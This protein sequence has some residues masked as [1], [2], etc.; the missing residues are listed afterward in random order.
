[1][2]QTSEMYRLSGGFCYQKTCG[3]C[4][5]YLGSKE[6]S[7]VLYPNEY[8]MEWGGGKMACKFFEEKHEKEQQMNI[9]S[10]FKMITKN[11]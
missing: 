3:E 8:G 11:Q 10:W 6:L 9:T 1:M 4:A 5:Y 2:I 7:C